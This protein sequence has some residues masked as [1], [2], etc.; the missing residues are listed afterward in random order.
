MFNNKTQTNSSE[1]FGF[2]PYCDQVIIAILLVIIIAVSLYFDVHLHSVFDLSKI[3]VLYILTFAAL[4]IWSIKTMTTL[5]KSS[6]TDSTLPTANTRRTS[7]HKAQPLTLPLLALLLSNGLSML[8]SINPYLSLVGTYKRYGGFISTLVYVS[9]FF[10]IVSFIDKRRLS[11]LLN[12]II[13]TAGIASVYGIFQHFGLDLYHWNTS[14]GYGIRVSST[15]G[16]PVFFSAFLIMVIP[17][18]L[19]K[20]FSCPPVHERTR[21]GS[22]VRYSTFLYLGILALLTIAFYYTKTRA[23]FVGL[24]IS[25]LFFFTMI[26]KET[27]LANKLKTI[28]A[29][30]ILAGISVFLN[31]HNETSVIERFRGDI[32]PSYSDGISGEKADNPHNKYLTEEEPA[33]PPSQPEDPAQYHSDWYAGLARQLE[34]TTLTRFLQY[35]AGLRI[36]YDYP[37]LGIG[38]DTLG[39]LY[40]QYIARLHREMDEHRGFENQNRI[41]CDLLNLTVSTGLLGLGA[42][43]WFAFAYSGMVWKGCKKSDGSG[44]ILIIGLCA[45][46]LAYFIQN[47]FGFGHVPIITLFWFL[48][49]L[50]VIACQPEKPGG[51]T[52]IR[53]LPSDNVQSPEAHNHGRAGWI[54][55]LP[56]GRFGKRVFCGIIACAMILLITL[57]LCRYKADIYFEHGRRSL[58]NNEIAAAIQSYEMAVKHNP[59]SLNYNNVLNGI[60]LKMAAISLSKNR[61]RATENMPDIFSRNQTAVWLSSTIDGA[62][63][64]QRLYP[65]DYH[66]AFTLGQAYRLLDKISP[67]RQR[68]PD[69]EA[70]MSEKA[71][72]YYKRAIALH[73]YKFEMRNQLAQLYAEEGQY[74]NAIPELKEAKSISPAN[75]ASYL[76][77]ASIYM[78]DRERYDEAEAVL[79]EYIKRN[80]DHAV[81][82]IHRLL[83]YLYFKTAKWENILEQS[84][85]I[86]QI[87]NAD[88]EA[89][90]YATMANFKLE[91][92]DDARNLCKRILDLTGPADNT[93]RT[94]AKEIL[95]I[96]PKK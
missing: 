85:Q 28:S 61:E 75:H 56:F 82:A 30:T 21:T 50:S 29:I 45:G 10:V 20:I 60:Y 44:K 15:F 49:A 92:Y 18:V 24:I 14:F 81:I 72:K 83:G 40:P 6:L 41:H 59:L 66:S 73:P 42:Y 12:V 34:G 39:M 80:P 95:E 2:T 36:L 7:F 16:H 54:D 37:V 55:R 9:L 90:K 69:G 78:N 27:L 52:A 74:E 43:V 33:F 79:L 87:D 31:V 64:V 4:A 8:F 51:A 17:L 32:R 96:L 46:C 65:M 48:I 68:H 1:E 57:S 35:R 58:N 93:Y 94:Y 76:N 19:V 47:Q 25:N 23:S 77:L 71:I 5:R 86:I 63:K 89:H 13:L 91:Q 11:S 26:G 84:K 3:T 70:D 22:N 88:L 38:E 53:H 67:A 62:E